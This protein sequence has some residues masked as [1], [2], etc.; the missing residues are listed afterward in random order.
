LEEKLMDITNKFEENVRTYQMDQKKWEKE[1]AV[2][3]QKVSLNQNQIDELKSK[4]KSL[5]ANL[6]ISKANMSKEVRDISLR[7]EKEREELKSE[8]NI[9]TERLNETCEELN[10]VKE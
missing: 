8:L 3:E 5:D 2:L 1:K 6:T 7:F 4:E 10:S 9:K